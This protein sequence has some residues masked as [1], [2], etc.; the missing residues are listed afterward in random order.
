M[1]AIP[2]PPSLL[3]MGVAFL[4]ICLCAQAA[5]QAAAA[6][7]ASPNYPESLNGIRD[8]HSDFINN[9]QSLN[10]GQLRLQGETIVFPWSSRR[11]SGICPS[12]ADVMPSFAPAKENIAIT[13]PCTEE[14]VK[15]LKAIN[16]VKQRDIVYQDSQIEKANRDLTNLMDVRVQGNHGRGGSPGD[17]LKDGDAE[18]FVDNALN[19]GDQND[20]YLLS[21]GPG[22]YMNIGVSGI[23]VSAVNTVEGG[24]AVA[25]SNIIIKP[26]QVIT[27]PS[28]IE[29]K[30][31]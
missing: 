26:V 22:N 3:L 10:M 6:W 20:K 1:N 30:L 21:H 31:Q 18:Q 16:A 13:G 7:P 17:A 23:T 27:C 9:K 4:L 2:K 5:A 28:E 15:D 11:V 12:N 19:S 8:Y 14:Q 29:E 25:T 24:S